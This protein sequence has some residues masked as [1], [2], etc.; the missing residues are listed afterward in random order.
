MLN[1]LAQDNEDDNGYDTKDGDESR[2]DLSPPA[3]LQQPNSWL[4]CGREGGSRG[5]T[6]SGG[7]PA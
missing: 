6:V 4:I 5:G 2:A 1:S 3:L 7:G